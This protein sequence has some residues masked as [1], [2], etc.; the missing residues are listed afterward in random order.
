[1]RLLTLIMAGFLLTGCTWVET[2][3]Q[4]EKVRI[5]TTKEVAACKR[6]GKTTVSLVAKIAGIER[7]KQKVK[8][9]LETLARNS[10]A[11]MGG[12]AVVAETEP[13][14]GKQTFGVYECSQ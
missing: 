6:L 2:T 7:N 13:E 14:D 11:D 9:E 5:A 8:S 3:S 1:M 10:A 4:G 12:N